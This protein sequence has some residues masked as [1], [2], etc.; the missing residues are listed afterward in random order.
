MHVTVVLLGFDGLGR[1]NI[2]LP[3][4]RRSFFLIIIIR[5]VLTLDSPFS[6]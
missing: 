1:E 5:N 2:K 3:E 4:V 6:G